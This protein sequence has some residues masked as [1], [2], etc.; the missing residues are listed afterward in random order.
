MSEE[1]IARLRK[2][3]EEDRQC[4]ANS[5][6]VADLLQPQMDAFE[7]CDGHNVY[8]VRMAVDHRNSVKRD[9]QYADDL[10]AAI[11]LLASPPAKPAPADGMRTLRLIADADPGPSSQQS[12]A[13][14]MA[15]M[16]KQALSTAQG[17]GA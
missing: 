7:A 13:H 9:T 11:A 15:L 2:R 10:E 16:A 3:M 5:K 8:A 6:I 12:L 4:A 1:L 14:E 17:E